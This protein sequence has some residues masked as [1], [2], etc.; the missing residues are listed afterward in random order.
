MLDM[1][2]KLDFP[3]L[4]FVKEGQLIR[5]KYDANDDPQESKLISIGSKTVKLYALDW[6]GFDERRKGKFE[7]WRN[8]YIKDPDTYNKLQYI[9]A[10][11]DPYEN[12]FSN[13]IFALDYKYLNEIHRHTELAY[14]EWGRSRGFDTMIRDICLDP[15]ATHIWVAFRLLCDC[16]YDEHIRY[17]SRNDWIGRCSR[18]ALCYKFWR[19]Q[20]GG[21]L[22]YGKANMQNL[23]LKNLKYCGIGDKSGWKDIQLFHDKI[24]EHEK[25]LSE[26]T[27]VWFKETEENVK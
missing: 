27:S 19:G 4:N 1:K 5:R 15:V 16:I 20:T 13:L 21:G 14:T 26:A 18:H 25:T 3:S 17:W 8:I 22:V 2:H 12:I 10:L 7:K 6:T 23:D 9:Q 24:L 11:P